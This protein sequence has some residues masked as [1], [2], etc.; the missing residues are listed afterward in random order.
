[1]KMIEDEVFP[2]G[3]PEAM[4]LTKFAKLLGVSNTQASRIAKSR[5]DMLVTYPTEKAP[6]V[7]TDFY[8]EIVGKQKK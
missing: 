7:K 2:D 5:P 6:R 4:N 1:M 8:L 3:F